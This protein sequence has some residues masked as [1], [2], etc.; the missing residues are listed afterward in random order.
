[1]SESPVSAWRTWVI[2]WASPTTILGA[3]ASTIR[4]ISRG[5]ARGLIGTA[6]M[7]PRRTP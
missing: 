4:E 3:Q 1:M 7:P 5:V 6:T 2:D